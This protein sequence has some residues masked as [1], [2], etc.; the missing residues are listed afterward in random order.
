VLMVAGHVVG[1]TASQ[2]MAVAD[3]SAWRYFYRI[4]EDLRMPL[5][6]VLSGF[7][8]A[9]RPLR[10]SSRFPNFVQG[11]ARRLLVPLVCVGA[12]FTAVQTLTPAANSQGQ[13]SDIWKVY[14]FGYGHF[15]FLQ[16]I[17]IVFLVVGL[18]DI[19]NALSSFRRWGVAL[20]VSSL[21]YVLVTV[22][23]QADLFSVSGALRLLPFFLLGYGLHVFE[24]RF[25]RSPALALTVAAFVPLFI[26]RLGDIYG[27]I[28]VA[29]LVERGLRM[30]VGIT[31]TA[32]LVLIR[33][34]VRINFLARIG[35]F[36]FGIY[37]LHV[38]GSAATRIVLEKVGL[39][40]NGLVFVACLVMGVA[41]P[42]A[43][44]LTLGRVSWISWAF[45]G[46]R[47]YGR[48]AATSGQAGKDPIHLEQSESGR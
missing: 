37:L 31:I 25:I 28:E 33:S 34:R 45:L 13:L 12:V 38:F 36:A 41:L 4:L 17:F 30:S 9:Y 5:F 3:D 42:I 14:L 40:N 32:I 24:E 2:G 35:Y 19:M 39:A 27:V 15:W 16:S 7:V 8:Y 44:E 21:L 6:S 22:P 18:L 23:P 29:P 11:K 46:Q 48:V 26:L 47:P 10:D 1:S 43:F 20:S